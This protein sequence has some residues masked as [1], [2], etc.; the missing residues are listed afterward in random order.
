MALILLRTVFAVACGFLLWNVPLR[1]RQALVYGPAFALLFFP[2]SCVEWQAK[3]GIVLSILHGMIHHRWPFIDASGYN[4]QHTPVYD[5][6][7]H[8]LMLLW[9]HLSFRNN[10]VMSGWTVGG[11]VHITPVDI[12]S[13]TMLFW[14]A[15]NCALAG[16]LKDSDDSTHCQFS[17]RSWFERTSVTQAFSSGYFMLAAL[18]LDLPASGW[19]TVTW[20][21]FVTICMFNWLFFRHISNTLLGRFFTRSYFEF[22]FITPACVGPM[23]AC[24]GL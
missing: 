21:V 7:C 10:I 18:L 12:I 4:K 3:V 1:Q 15:I 22:A 9:A 13:G 23:F 11:M 8:E 16:C 14:G 17:V 2:L 24:L 20:V 5:V 6:I 19:M